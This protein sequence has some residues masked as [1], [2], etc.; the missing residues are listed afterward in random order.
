MLGGVWRFFFPLRG[1]RVLSRKAAKAASHLRAWLAS[2]PDDF[3]KQTRAALELGCDHFTA[4]EIRVA[5][6]GLF[7]AGKSS[8]LNAVIREDLLPAAD[9]AETGAGTWIR[10][11]RRSGRAVLPDGSAVR[12][13]PTRDNIAVHASIRGKDQRGRRADSE[14]AD[15]V[16]VYL[17]APGLPKQVCLIDVPGLN[18]KHEISDRAMRTL[19]CA[20]WVVW[21]FRSDPAFSETDAKCIAEVV[22]FIGES[23]IRFV[24]NARLDADDV[25]NWRGFI[26]KEA[27]IANETL[28][29]FT[30]AMQFENS[31]H[32]PIVVSARGARKKRGTFGMKDLSR[33]LNQVF[34]EG[35]AETLQMRLR[36]LE[37]TLSDAETWLKAV[38]RAHQ[39]HLEQK[40]AAYESYEKARKAQEAFGKEWRAALKTAYDA[41]DK[42]L[43]E[44]ADTRAGQ[45]RDHAYS[46][47]EKVGFSVSGPASAAVMEAAESIAS[48]CT[49]AWRKHLGTN[50]PSDL[51][52]T[53][54]ASFAG[55]MRPGTSADI[56]AKAEKAVG[57]LKAPWVHRDFDD[58]MSQWFGRDQ[59]K[60]RAAEKHRREIG[61][62]AG[63][64]KAAFTAYQPEMERRLSHM[65]VLPSL[66]PAPPPDPARKN[67]HDALAS[68]YETMRAKLKSA[69]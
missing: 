29:D 56:L 16:E 51:L 7:K 18:D 45:V 15:R 58:R 67:A 52:P 39:A 53:V 31:P 28:C 55:V 4:P 62:A 38:A 20:D 57:D 37:P 34:L 24:L 64:L 3:P 6:G 66:Q 48:S 40:T 44:I 33:F 65:F 50:S 17:P 49:Q 21:V 19:R 60:L 9:L 41:L 2:A 27:R 25:G 35:P 1:R 14:L 59:A 10:R 26:A 61:A 43:G 13:K 63:E 54:L 30:K 22:S 42:Q 69:V 32:A 12:F 11:G 47:G 8:L 36:S 46:E 5:F 68:S 23:R